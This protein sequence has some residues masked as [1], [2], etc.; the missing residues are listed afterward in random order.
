MSA[1]L[2][3]ADAARGLTVGVHG[4]TFGGNPLAMAIGNA[5]LDIIL[6]PGFI[7]HVAQLGLNLRQRLAEL[8]DRHGSVIDEIR[9]EGL[10]VGL[11]LK[12]PPA[13]FAEAALTQKISSFRRAT[14]SCGCCR[15]S[16]SPRRNSPKVCGVSTL[17]APRSKSASSSRPT[18]DRMNAPV[19]AAPRHFLGLIDLS[20]VELRRI[21]DLSAAMKKARVKGAPPAWRPLAGKTWPS[22]STGPRPAPACRSTSACA[23][24]AAR[25]SC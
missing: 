20:T 8:K 10:M 18:D 3:T 24:S 23:N 13:E 14:M 19:Q 4:T 5:T 25:R 22:S 17:L 9:G 16:S 11:R 1:C 2:A 12:V 15:R 21:L 7:E 6:A